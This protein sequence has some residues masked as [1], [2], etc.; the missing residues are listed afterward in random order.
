VVVSNP[1]QIGQSYWLVRPL[2][3]CRIGG[4]DEIVAY[5]GDE[6]FMWQSDT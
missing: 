1:M 6:M 2:A 4:F 5:V 3:E